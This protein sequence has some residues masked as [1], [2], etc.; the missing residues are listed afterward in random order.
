MTMIAASKMDLSTIHR[1]GLIGDVHTEAELLERAIEDLRE[2][3]ADIV[4]CV[5]DIANGR[6]DLAR[7]CDLLEHHDVITVRGNHDRWLL[8]DLAQD[9]EDPAVKRRLPAAIVKHLAQLRQDIPART[10]RFLTS[11]PATRTFATSRG[12]LMLC[13]GLGPNDVA[14]ITPDESAESVAANIELQALLAS[15]GLRLVLNGHTH[16]R[17]VRSV[18]HLTIINAGT[19]H[20]AQ[21]PGAVLLDLARGNVLWLP[22]VEGSS[23]APELLGTLA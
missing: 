22:L 10:A 13:H 11:L 1:I 5:G 19:L 15:P 2:L 20:P 7:C 18:D 14:G 3:G 23:P 8:N 9:P 12:E 21:E 4:F 6:G 17:M 16:H